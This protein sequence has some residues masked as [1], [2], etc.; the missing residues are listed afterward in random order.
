VPQ[1]YPG[2]CRN[3]NGKATPK[4]HNCCKEGSGKEEDRYKKTS[5]SEEECREEEDR[6]FSEEEGW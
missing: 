3:S 1:R 4:S 6:D 2:I 5:S